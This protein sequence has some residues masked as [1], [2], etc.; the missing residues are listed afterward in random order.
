M[1]VSGQFE[2]GEKLPTEK[3]LAAMLGIGRNSLRE[4]IRALSLLGFVQVKVPDGMFIT[5]RNDNFFMRQQKMTRVYSSINVLVEARVVL[6]C[7]LIRM[8]ALKIKDPIKQELAELL[9]E[10]EQDSDYGIWQNYDIKFHMGLADAADNPFLKQT[11]L[12]LLDGIN[13]WIHINLKNEAI[14]PIRQLA[15]IQH[16]EIFQAVCE[17]NEVQAEERMRLHLSYTDCMFTSYTEA[18]ES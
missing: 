5:Y 10:M 12:V 6:E 4:A 7:G 2:P 16:K 1:I 14:N 17:R 9:A 13:E 15:Y 3:E 8:S 18:H 11:L